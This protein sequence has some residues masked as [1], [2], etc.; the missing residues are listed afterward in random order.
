MPV[1]ACPDRKELT[2]WSVGRLSDQQLQEIAAHLE[3]CNACSS[4][5][6]ELAA[7]D[8]SLLSDLRAPVPSN[9]YLD[10]PTCREAVARFV[11]V[12]SKRGETARP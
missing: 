9:P 8:D 10:E 4:S 12:V 2:A 6:E 11:A 7:T 1:S 3:D 5:L